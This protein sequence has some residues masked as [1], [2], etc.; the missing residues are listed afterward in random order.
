MRFLLLTTC[1]AVALGCGRTEYDG[2]FGESSSSGGREALGG[3]SSLGGRGLGGSGNVATGGAGSEAAS[4]GTGGI[5]EPPP[6][7]CSFD[8]QNGSAPAP[9]RLWRLTPVEYANTVGAFLNGRRQGSAP[10]VPMPSTFENPLS[11]PDARYTTTSGAVTLSDPEMR[12]V[13]RT[14]ADI[15]SLLVQNLKTGSC[16]ATDS[17]LAFESCVST[18]LQ[19]KGAILFR[20]PLLPEEAARYLKVAT[21]THLEADADT[22]LAAAFQAMLMAPQFLFKPEIGVNAGIQ[23]VYKLTPYEVAAMLAYALTMAPPDVELWNAASNGALNTP[24]Q[25]KAQVVR[26]MSLPA[27]AGAR[28]F[29]TEYFKL[30]A[31]RGVAKDAQPGAPAACGYNKDRLVLQAEAL[32]ED[33]YQSNYQSN[34]ISTLFTTQNVFVDCGSQ[35]LYGLTGAPPDTGPPAKM[36]ALPGQRAGFLT[37][38]AWLGAMATRDETKPVRRGLFITEDVLCTDIPEMD[39]SSV[40]PLGDDPS[41]TMRERFAAHAAPNSSCRPC[42]AL[43]DPPGLAFENY[44]TVG[45]YRTMESGKVI[46]ASG[47]LT[48]VDDASVSFTDGADLSMKLANTRRVQECVMRNAFRYFLGRMEGAQ[49]SCALLNAANAYA[50]SGS[51]VE[52]VAALAASDPF[53]NRSF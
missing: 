27:A 32:V 40:P 48:G 1:V 43:L 14:S 31:I 29:V 13:F 33:V 46:D 4:G 11:E 44:D 26:L 49:D 16:W 21:D 35:N 45:A 3:M 52:F 34:F 25:I 50:A 22:S 2:A 19:E 5:V 23:S 53:L 15:A 30:R 17:A 41:L 36:L 10:V 38:P 51:Y 9:R 24:D 37:N 39:P 47:A 18:L 12:G 28:N 6:P 7:R 20:R 42:H 8:S